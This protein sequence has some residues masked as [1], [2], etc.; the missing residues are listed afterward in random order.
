[1]ST[2][3]IHC[4]EAE[5]LLDALSPRSRLFNWITRPQEFL[6]RGHSDSRYQL[7]PSALRV[8]NRITIDGD[9][10]VV[11]A[12]WDNETQ[13]K[14][15]ARALAQFFWRADESGL[16]LP[17]DGQILRRAFSQMA[18]LEPRAWP[19][20]EFLSLLALAQHNG[21]PT[22]LL[23]WTRS[24]RVACYFAAFTAAERLQGASPPPPSGAR[25]LS[26]WA[27]QAM[28]VEL[29]RRL[30]VVNPSVRI[31]LVTAPRSSNSNLH[32]QKG[33]FTLFVDTGIKPKDPVDRSPL[34]VL[35]SR[36][37]PPFRLLHFTLPVNESPKLLRLLALEGVNAASLFPGYG[38]VIRA[39]REE[40]L[41]D[42]KPSSLGDTMPDLLGSAIRSDVTVDYSEDLG[43]VPGRPAPPPI[44]RRS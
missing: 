35:S 36:L 8:G 2:I 15:E 39:L 27:F 44:P 42:R 18:D 30:A 10:V 13:A 12:S 22:R 33:I 28:N 16:P 1:M 17:E 3:T 29:Q 14:R 25:T 34:D 19:Q 26:V 38:G 20:E 6:F 41:W 5:E 23:D 21:L 37:K 11:D 7:L 31:E 4:S 24:S 32:A 43:T 40:T 9:E